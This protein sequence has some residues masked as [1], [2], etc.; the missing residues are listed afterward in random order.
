MNI[1]NHDPK[2]KA[3]LDV[4]EGKLEGLIA[5]NPDDAGFWVAFERESNPIFEIADEHETEYA[6]G[7]ID[8][9]LKNAGRIPG[10]EEGVPCA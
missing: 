1:H 5:Q 10:E 8:C 3:R 7:R 4:L 2:L 9:M 6:Q